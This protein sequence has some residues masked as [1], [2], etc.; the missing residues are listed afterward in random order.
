[1]DPD[2]YEARLTVEARERCRRW[3][4]YAD[5]RLGPAGVPI[6]I[7]PG[8]DDPPEIDS[9]FDGSKVFV[10]GGDDV[11]DLDGTAFATV[12]WS[13]PTPWHTPRE[14]GEDE[15]EARLRRAIGRLPDPAKA[16]FNFHAPP[17]DTRLDICNKLDDDLRVVTV[18]GNPIPMHA[19]STAVRKVIEEFQPRASLHGH[20]HES[21]AN[22]TLGRTLALNPGSEY[23]EGV[24]QGAIVSIEND[25][26]HHTFTSG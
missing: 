23:S 4:D 9:A 14:C 16:I 21:R 22:Q 15:L 25:A 2:A 24:L 19:G 7:A 1:M 12:G 18:M 13:N 8:N 17:Y 11:V 3:V 26:V 20:I 10:N 5:D 6:L